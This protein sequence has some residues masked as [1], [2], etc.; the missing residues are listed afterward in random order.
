M[1]TQENSGRVISF[2]TA[3]SIV[4]CSG[5]HLDYVGLE[6]PVLDGLAQLQ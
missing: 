2:N 6:G 3:Q 5:E 4:E 1:V